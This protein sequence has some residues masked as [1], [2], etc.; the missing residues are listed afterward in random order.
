MVASSSS[1][2]RPPFSV[3]CTAK[4]T[5]GKRGSDT[6]GSISTLGF[7]RMRP[8]AA[9]AR[10]RKAYELHSPYAYLNFPEDFRR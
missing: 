3:L 10:D 5:N 8:E 2:L 9:K 4:G 1:V 7:S 6:E